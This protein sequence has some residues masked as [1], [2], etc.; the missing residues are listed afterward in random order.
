MRLGPMSTSCV[1]IALGVLAVQVLRRSSRHRV[2]HNRHQQESAPRLSYSLA[3]PPFL[4]PLPSFPCLP[5]LSPPPPPPFM[6][7]LV[8]SSVFL[9]FLPPALL[10]CLH[11]PPCFLMLFVCLCACDLVPPS[12]LW[13]RGNRFVHISGDVVD[14]ALACIHA[15]SQP[16]SNFSQFG[17]SLELL[18]A[19]SCGRRRHGVWPFPFRRAS[20]CASLCRI[21]GRLLRW[22]SGACLRALTWRRAALVVYSPPCGMMQIARRWPHFCA[23]VP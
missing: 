8:S 3:L 5:S 1:T 16:G 12:S 21:V 18:A 23:S 22:V 14:S 6:R 10:A 4:P 17:P 9:P 13:A 15:C 19:S 11:A 2:R 7:P 20:A